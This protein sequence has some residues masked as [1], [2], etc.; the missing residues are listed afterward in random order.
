MR[1]S[2][3]PA[4]ISTLIAIC[5]L[6]PGELLSAPKDYD[7]MYQLS[8]GSSSNKFDTDILIDSRNGA[9]SG[10]LDLEDDL[11]FDNE[12][13]L[14]WITAH[15]RMADRHRL[16]L[17]Y[18]PIRRTS[19]FENNKDIDLGDRVIKAGASISSEVKTYLF[20][21]QYTYSFY[22]DAETEVG[23]SGGLYWM[24]SLTSINA[25]GVLQAT[26]SEDEQFLESFERSQRLVVPLP[27]FGLSV[28]HWL[29]DTWN[30]NANARVLD[31]TINDVDGY[32]LNMS[33]DTSYYFTD[34]VGIGLSFTSFDLRVTQQ[35]VIFI[36]SVEYQYTGLL[37]YVTLRY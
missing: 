7:E 20:D 13:R 29:T 19:Y 15:W 31:V 5:S 28:S 6:L 14:T 8:A 17:I 35:R 25:E 4:G 22:K 26:G 18:T 3:K 9:I 32:L 1:R 12:V 21:I 27:L 24:N 36:N 23:I 34:Q 30:L 37:G 16:E 2:Y 33:I 10:G 11:G